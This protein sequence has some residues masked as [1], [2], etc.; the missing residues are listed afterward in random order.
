MKLIAIFLILSAV[1]AI[2]V[3]DI[4]D[5]Y[6]GLKGI[7]KSIKP[8]GCDALKIFLQTTISYTED[9][10]KNKQVFEEMLNLF[11]SNKEKFGL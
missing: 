3:H 7:Y 5:F 9:E 8:I 1:S 2:T 6:H 11:C 10:S 4:V